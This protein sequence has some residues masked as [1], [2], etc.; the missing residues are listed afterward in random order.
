M[1]NREI[2]N[3]EN[4]NVWLKHG[5]EEISVVK[6]LG[7]SI[8]K[9]GTLGI[10]GESGSGKSVT[11]SSVLG[12]LD[13]KKW[14]S[15]G[16]VEFMGKPL[17]YESKKQMNKLRG[18]KI[19]WI[20]QNPMSA[21]NP[22]FKIAYHFQETALAHGRKN[23][24]ETRELA[25]R[26][27]KKMH[28]HE[29]ERVLES[30]PFQLS[31]G[32]LQRVMIALAL[33]Q[34]PELLIADEPT[35]ALDLTVQYDIIKLLKEMQGE[36]H[37]AILLVS[38][39]LGVISEIADE[40]L[41]MYAGEMVE[42]SV[43]DSILKQPVHAYTRGLFLSRPAFS[44]ERLPVLAGQ[45]SSVVNRKEGCAFYERCPIRTE[46]C[47]RQDIP[48]SVVGEKHIVR[49]LEKEKQHGIINSGKGQKSI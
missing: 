4:L 26:M 37:M 42:R 7:F 34:E 30:Y 32:M 39:D 1:E 16:K 18:G 17:P 23:R 28:I 21:F 14:K 49:C 46:L 31:G 8:K 45:A 12:L 38:H 22:L 47:R 44:K 9:G 35:T 20:T 41:V 36:L 33:I 25:K 5:K 2:L 13:D 6:D 43:T 10:I 27:L 40:I 11:C 3:V 29:P 19:A 24:H 15:Q 48:C